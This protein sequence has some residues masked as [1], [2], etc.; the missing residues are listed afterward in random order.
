M[1]K[2]ISILYQ[3]LKH[4]GPKRWLGTFWIEI[5]DDNYLQVEHSRL[6]LKYLFFISR[7]HARIK[8]LY[9]VILCI[10]KQETVSKNECE[11]WPVAFIPWAVLAG[12]V[13]IDR[14]SLADWLIELYYWQQ[15]IN[16]HKGFFEKLA[17]KVPLPRKAKNIKSTSH[18]LLKLGFRLARGITHSRSR[19]HS[20]SLSAIVLNRVTERSGEIDWD[21]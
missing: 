15:F 2:N 16:A 9:V 3:C 7:F 1:W 20:P 11:Y 8:K 4:S 19:L 12:R 18:S 5:F 17:L 13:T 14:Y 21:S 10:N 6:T